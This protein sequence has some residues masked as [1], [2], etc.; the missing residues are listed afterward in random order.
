[1]ETRLGD[2]RSLLTVPNV[3]STLAVFLVLAGGT[4]L[5]AGLKKNS[6]SSRTVRDNSLVSTDLADGRGVKGADV[7][8]GSLGGADV[9]DGSLGGGSFAAGSVSGADL[10]DG[11]VGADAIG[12]GEIGRAQLG[13]KSVNSA[14]IADGALGD[15]D[16]APHS[17]GGRNVVEST[18]TKVPDASRLGGL[19]PGAF[20]SALIFEPASALE[21]G[22][23]VGDGTFKISES[24]P[25]G[26]LM[27]SGG[28][29]EVG[30][31]STLVESF[32]K[33][34]TWTVRINPHGSVDPFR[35]SLTCASQAGL[36][37]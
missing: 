14:T 35:V 23:P 33:N 28:P 8:D 16:F 15:A 29:S 13:L 34:G 17:I 2:L 21:V 3:L 4:A 22:I 19:P 37:R 32:P 18:L 1:M 9:A 25:P 6:V 31:R 26:D 27:L 24:C 20:V 30:N 5:A 10:A 11:S 7:A 36:P 12:D